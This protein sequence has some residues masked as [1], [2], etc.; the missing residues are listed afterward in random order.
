MISQIRSGG[1]PLVCAK[2]QVD[3]MAPSRGFFSIKNLFK[4]EY[5]VH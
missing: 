3:P 5:S 4:D 2:E 1:I